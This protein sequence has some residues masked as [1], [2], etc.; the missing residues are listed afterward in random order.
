MFKTRDYQGGT[1]GDEQTLSLDVYRRAIVFKSHAT[2]SVL[3][4]LSK[5]LDKFLYLLYSIK[6]RPIVDLT[7]QVET[8]LPVNA[9]PNQRNAA[10]MEGS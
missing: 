10:F 2:L 8:K 9:A 3:S 6:R 4:I 7:W 5:K 1:T